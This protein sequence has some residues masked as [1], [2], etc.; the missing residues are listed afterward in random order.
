MSPREIRLVIARSA[1]CD[2][3]ISTLNNGIASLKSARNDAF[4]I[5]YSAPNALRMSR[6]CIM[7]WR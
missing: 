6:A 2:E 1:F 4:S 3:A 7:L 5:V